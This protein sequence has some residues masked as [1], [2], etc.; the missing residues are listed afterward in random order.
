MKVGIDGNP[1]SS[2]PSAESS[3]KSTEVFLYWIALLPA[4]GTVA[5]V[6][7]LYR[8]GDVLI[9]KVIALPESRE[10]LPHAVLAHGEM[11]GHS[12]RIAEMTA[13]DVYQ[14]L[15]EL[16]LDVHGESATV[17]HEEHEPIVL[18]RG[19]YRV[20]RQREYSPQEVR[21]VRD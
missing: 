13:V 10:K 4:A 15:E 14:G 8:H 6:H 21:I 12:H 17:V 19:F 2:N 3:G 20:W 18:E 16:Y 9:E 11:T 5:R 1:S 7:T